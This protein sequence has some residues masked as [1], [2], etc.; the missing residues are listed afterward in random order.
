MKVEIALKYENGQF[1]PY[2]HIMA[3]Y[4]AESLKDGDWLSGECSVAN[5]RGLRSRMQNSAMWLFCTKIAKA[6]NSAGLDMAV[7][8]KDTNYSISWSENSVK[9]HIWGVISQALHG[10]EKSSHLDTKQFCE[11]GE[12]MG[13]RL[14]MSKGISV[15]WPSRNSLMLEQLDKVNE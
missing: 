5:R 8:Y 15:E 12:E 13:R 2:N 14:A 6:L 7:F 3:E 4:Y 1:V 9:E 11:V 10:T